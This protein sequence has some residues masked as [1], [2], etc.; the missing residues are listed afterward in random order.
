MIYN[1][2]LTTSFLGTKYNGWQRQKNG[3]GIQQVIEDRLER[4]FKQKITVIGCCRTDS[5]VHALKHVS[6][7]K[8]K[9]GIEPADIKRFLNAT[10]PRDISV[11]D[12]EKVN[13]KFHARFDAKGKTYIYKVY[14]KP[15]PFLF[16]RGW[17]FDKKFDLVKILEGV[18]VLKRHKNLISIAKK[19]EYLRE[20]I[21]LREL[22][23]R[24]DGT[25]LEFHI[26]ASHFLR[27]LVRGIVGHLMAIGR[28]SLDL[29][30]FD[31]ILAYKD[32]EKGKFSAPAEGLF[33]KDIYY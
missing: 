14:T 13:E 27:G 3:I 6:N 5:G 16:G 2:K 25:V 31:K 30:E 19:G 1:Y 15:D 32:P 33:L 23:I 7:F 12:V 24:F 22:K 4:F 28:G 18:E 17:Y 20:E 9:K 11:L 21:D 26:T 29:E 10:L 8:T